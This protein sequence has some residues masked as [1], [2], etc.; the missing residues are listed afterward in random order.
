MSEQEF[1]TY[2]AQVCTRLGLPAGRRRKIRQELRDH[3][4]QH[5]EEISPS[6]RVRQERIDQVLADFGPPDRLAAAIA[7]PYQRRVW[8]IAG[9]V[10]ASLVVTA[11]IQMQLR[12]GSSPVRPS[13]EGSLAG[14]SVLAAGGGPL[15]AQIIGG[16][17][18][19][20]P[21]DEALR[22]LSEHI[23][24]VSFHD[25]PLE[26]VFDFL[27]EQTEANIW[28]NWSALEVVGVDRDTSVSIQLEDVVLGRL[29]D[30]LCAQA[31]DGRDMVFGQGGN[32][33]EISTGDRLRSPTP[34]IDT[35]QAVYDVRRII[36][37]AETRWAARPQEDP[38]LKEG[39]HNL[40]PVWTNTAAKLSSIITDSIAPDI[41]R[42]N[43][44]LHSAIVHFAGLLVVQAP[45]VTQGQIADL[46]AQLEGRLARGSARASMAAPAPPA[47]STSAAGGRAVRGAV[48]PGPA[49]TEKKAQKAKKAK[50]GKKAKKAKKAKQKSKEDQT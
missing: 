17:A 35:V 41:W 19:P 11:L 29:L 36:D 9:A 16:G 13:W 28:V 14:G 32:V 12:H 46:L 20:Q 47:D 10:A 49:Q 38:R 33:I 15:L 40:G 44:G 39:G 8:R 45:S 50:Q 21:Q 2:L 5:W 30:L 3:L 48:P 7:R 25:D 34:D 42:C 18:E 43:G 27:R 23:P 24:V 26:S 4:D 31:G 37:A 6:G 22:A 1:E